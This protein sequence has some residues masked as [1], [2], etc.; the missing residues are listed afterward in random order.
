MR[1]FARFAWAVLVWNL[2]VV[3]WG[4]FVRATGSGAGCGQHWPLCNGVVLP[5][6]PALATAIELT[7]RITS[8]ISILLVVA[9][10]AWAL[11]A[12]PRRH[13]ARRAAIA[14]GILIVTEALVG[15]G[16]VLFGWVASDASLARGWVVAIHLVNT[17]LLLAAIALAAAFADRPSA[18][19]LADRGPLAA[20]LLLALATTMTAGATGA[21]A[22]LGDSLFPATS[23]AEGLRQETSAGASIL[24]RLRVLHPFAAVAGAIALVAF[25][26]SALRARPSDE[27]VHRLGVALLGLVGLELAAGAL[28]LALLAPVWLQLVHLLVADLVWL[29]LVL[30][31]AAALS[32]A[33][34]FEGGTALTPALRE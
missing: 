21:I 11:R 10:V 14:A 17:F 9:L 34:A 24:L 28:N 8:G 33:P 30:L 20:V 23:F 1:A 27:R 26:R 2:A 12:F 15:A 6:A 32:P 25:A 16:L 5:R 7:H 4:A 13:A 29:V 31:G 3:A 19:Q 22:A 18:L